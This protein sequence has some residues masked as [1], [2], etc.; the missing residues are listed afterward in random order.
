MTITIYFYIRY[1]DNEQVESE[2]LSNSTLNIERVPFEEFK[3]G[4]EET[5]I[6]LI[7]YDINL[8]IQKNL[9]VNL[10]KEDQLQYY[11]RENSEHIII[12]AEE[13]IIKIN[14]YN[15]NIDNQKFINNSLSGYPTQIRSNLIEQK[16]QYCSDSLIVS[17][18]YE[19]LDDYGHDVITYFDYYY[20]NS[21]KIMI[22][23]SYVENDIKESK[24][25][26]LLSRVLPQLYST[27]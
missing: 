21:F 27:G 26:E 4:L 8:S 1:N 12:Y 9:F 24:Y 6:Y 18:R 23:S 17:Y 13:L 22:N 14:T 25:R 20:F 19:S 7:K 2:S 3:D 15:T 5:D 10:L 16:C 11:T